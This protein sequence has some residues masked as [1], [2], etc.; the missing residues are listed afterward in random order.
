M[1]KFKFTTLLQLQLSD[2]EENIKPQG[3]AQ[4]RACLCEARKPG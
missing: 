1:I 3:V 4:M 2:S